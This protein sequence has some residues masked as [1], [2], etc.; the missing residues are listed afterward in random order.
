MSHVFCMGMEEALDDFGSSFPRTNLPKEVMQFPDFP[1]PEKEESFVH[2]A[3][4]LNYLE[5][6]AMHY[7]LHQY[8]KVTLILVH[9][10]FQDLKIN[11]RQKIYVSVASS[12]V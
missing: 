2:H 3:D 4:V 11:Q 9:I 6:Y 10:L 1:F 7:N 5:D 12:V 8:I